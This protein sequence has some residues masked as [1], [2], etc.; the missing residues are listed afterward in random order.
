M[1]L[2]CYLALGGLSDLTGQRNSNAAHACTCMHTCMDLQG[3]MHVRSMDPEHSDIKHLIMKS[4]WHCRARKKEIAIENGSAQKGLRYL[5]A[6]H[7]LGQG[8]KDSHS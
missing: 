7:A 4:L 2:A 6:N 5:S 1:R 8:L 3:N